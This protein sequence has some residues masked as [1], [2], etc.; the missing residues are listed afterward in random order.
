MFSNPDQQRRWDYWYDAALQRAYPPEIAKQIVDQYVAQ[1]GYGKSNTHFLDTA[2]PRKYLG[3][4][5]NLNQSQLGVVQANQHAASAAAEHQAQV[6]AKQHAQAAQARDLKAQGLSPLHIAITQGNKEEVQR[7]LDSGKAGV[8][9]LSPTGYTPL[10]LAALGGHPEIANMLLGSGANPSLKSEGESMTPWE[11]ARMHGNTGVSESIEQANYASETEAQAE[12]NIISSVNRQAEMKGIDEGL[13]WVPKEFRL[14]TQVANMQGPSGASAAASFLPYGPSSSSSS[15]SALAPSSF[16]SSSSS[17]SGSHASGSDPRIFGAPVHPAAAGGEDKYADEARMIAAEAAPR[18]NLLDRFRP[19][20]YGAAAPPIP[21]LAAAHPAAPAPA[22]PLRPQANSFY[23]PEEGEVGY[24]DFQRRS[25]A[26]Y[27]GP[28]FASGG[29]VNAHGRFK[30][31]PAEQAYIMQAQ[32]QKNMTGDPGSPL[33]RGSIAAAQS[34]R[35][36]PLSDK[37]H[38][39]AIGKGL[40]NFSQKFVNPPQSNYD[41]FTHFAQSLTPA[42]GAYGAGMEQ[43][44]LANEK[45]MK[46]QFEKEMME[47][48]MQKQ[49][50]YRQQKMG[51]DQIYKNMR[52]GLEKARLNESKSYH[53]KSLAKK[54]I[55]NTDAYE[56]RQE[57]KQVSLLNKQELELKKYKNQIMKDRMEEY[58]FSSKEKK[59]AAR[60]VIESEVDAEIYPML[61]QVQDQLESYRKPV[62][63]KALEQYNTNLD[64]QAKSIVDE[65]S[66]LEAEL[67]AL[68]G[69]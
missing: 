64:T 36:M 9:T 46:E 15:N 48:K 16:S 40:L 11:L 44:E 45:L 65:E 25:D 33:Q 1:N 19:E 43:E 4:T 57:E 2:I 30:M 28:G 42:F 22:A 49:A 66:A 20:S 54:G 47:K 26:F 3:Q 55:K 41:A 34:V 69:G 63:A 27:G 31:S 17:S 62:G 32:E 58:K 29:E 35:A 52:L 53:E 37:Q 59:A 12:Q 21:A 6:Q 13:P 38:R 23:G 5:E 39:K 56:K 68:K 14:S 60:K 18:G 51:M 8:D 67:K 50:E 7:L 24:D 10:H 61:K